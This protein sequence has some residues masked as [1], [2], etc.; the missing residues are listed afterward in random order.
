MN[1]ARSVGL[2]K[3]SLD[4]F[5]WR[6]KDSSAFKFNVAPSR[7]DGQGLFALTG[8]PSRRKIGELTGERITRA[9]ARRRANRRERVAIVELYDGTAIDAE[10]GGNE[11]AFI[12][13]ACR[14][15]LYMRILGAHVEFYTLR[16]IAAGEELTC[17]YGETHHDGQ[18]RCGCRSD[19][20][21][22]F[23]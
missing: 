15:N 16:R 11:F 14:P 7:I 23:I 19:N 12:N 20:C 18:R 13:H 3:E 17:N 10:R 5:M 6:K 21:R 22:G 2:S 4:N 1:Q 8:L 9:A